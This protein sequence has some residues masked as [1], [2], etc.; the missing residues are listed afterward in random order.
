[1]SFLRRLL[2]SDEPKAEPEPAAWPAEGEGPFDV[3]DE[4]GD[5]HYRIT[6][7]DV[8]A[9]EEEKRVR[10]FVELLATQP[11]VREAVHEDREVILVKAR[12]LDRHAMQLAAERTWRAAE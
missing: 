7:D 3:E 2:G 9:H 11:G 8:I 4:G 12:G 10:A 1:M 6:F 5:W